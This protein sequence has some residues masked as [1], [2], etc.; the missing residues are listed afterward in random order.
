MQQFAHQAPALVVALSKPVAAS[1]IPLWEQQL[2]AG[3][4][5]MNFLNAV[6][7][8]GFVGSWL[9]GWPAY[10]HAVR[11]AFGDRD[12]T[13]AGFLFMGSPGRLLEERPRPEF[14]TIVSH[15]Q[16]KK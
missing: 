14:D 15:W 8:L 3:A 2:S 16:P 7:A 11:D 10:A 9:T 5:C 12:E 13:I 1:K 6:H 4:A